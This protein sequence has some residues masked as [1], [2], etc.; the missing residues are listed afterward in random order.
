M[1]LGYYD[2]WTGIYHANEIVSTEYVLSP[3]QGGGRGGESFGGR[4]QSSGR[5]GVVTPQAGG[6]GTP[7]R[8]GGSGAAA[9]APA[10]EEKPM[11]EAKNS[12]ITEILSPAEIEEGVMETDGNV[13]A[14]KI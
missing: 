11:F 3:N 9:N 7:S 8:G 12:T 13:A 14:E 6:G 10:E 5:A 4:G 1:T 2:E